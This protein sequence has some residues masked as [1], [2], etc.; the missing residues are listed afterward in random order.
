MPNFSLIAIVALAVATPSL[1]SCQDHSADLAR[2]WQADCEAAGF[3]GRTT[4]LTACIASR[5]ANYEAES[6]SAPANL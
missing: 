3:R 6:L 4:G 5:R 1:Q 2:Q